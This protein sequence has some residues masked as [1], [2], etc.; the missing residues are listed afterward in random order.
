MFCPV[1]RGS[2]KISEVVM[3]MQLCS[4]FAIHPFTM[5]LLSSE[6]SVLSFNYNFAAFSR[7]SSPDLVAEQYHHSVIDVSTVFNIV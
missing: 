7:K 1:D 2:K 3:P 6:V 4:K 5:F